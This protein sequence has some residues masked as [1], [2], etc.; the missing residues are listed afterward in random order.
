MGIAE[1]NIVNMIMKDVSPHGI[2]LFK[3]VRG[4]FYTLDSVRALIGAVKSFNKTL[5]ISAIQNLRQLKA[6]LQVPGASD[7]VGFTP[8]IITPEMVGQKIAIF[9]ALEVKTDTGKPSPEQLHFCAV[10]QESGG[11]SGIAR[12]SDDAQKILKIKC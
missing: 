1:T 12:N 11:F 10:V 9:T 3:N 6:G 5:I 2:R 7:L 8:V 4:Q